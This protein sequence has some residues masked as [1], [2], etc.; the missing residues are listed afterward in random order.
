MHTE[1]R[2]PRWNHLLI[3]LPLGTS[4]IRTGQPNMMEVIYLV[5]SFIIWNDLTHIVFFPTWIPGR[6]SHS[7]ANLDLFIYFDSSFCPK[8]AFPP[9]GT[10]DYVIVTVSIDFPINSKQDAWLITTSALIGMVL[11][12]IWE[13]FH[14]NISLKWVLLLLLQRFLSGFRLEL[15]YISL[16]VSIRSNLTHL[17]GF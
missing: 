12:I 2:F 14:G 7:P 16:I 6:D 13:M 11:V 5:N 9:L 1:M 10:S 3:C 4:I 17:Q 8:M 15:I